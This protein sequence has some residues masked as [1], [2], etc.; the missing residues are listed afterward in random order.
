MAKILI[1]EDHPDTREIL[2]V[3]L[4][5]DKHEVV[6]AHSG[7]EGVGKAK[8]FN[9]DLI[10]MDISLA[11]EINGWEA[12][13]RL[14]ADS[15]FDRTIIVALTAH[16]MKEDRERSFAH[17]C[18]EYWTKPIIDFEEFQRMIIELVAR[19]RHAAVETGG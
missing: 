18:D 14:R 7:E 10:L 15:F 9:P 8:Q 11:G 1:V 5:L 2:R 17:G 19:G 6:E 4:E 12:T 3:M 16:A 13:R